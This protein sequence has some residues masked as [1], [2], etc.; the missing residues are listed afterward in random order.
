MKPLRIKLQNE[1]RSKKIAQH[2]I[3]KDYALSYVLAGISK[4]PKLSQSLIFKGGTALKKIFFGD[5]RFSEDLD[6]STINAPKGMELE[7]SLQNA[8]AISK[9]F[10]LQ[11]GPFELELKRNP[12]RA[13]HPN[14]QDAFNIFIKFP[15]QPTPMCRIKIEITHDEPVI[16]PPEYKP[17]LHNYEEAL[18][19][20]VVC[21][22]IEEIIAEKLRALLQTHQKLVARGWN[23]PRARDYYDLWCVLK[24]YKNPRAYARGIFP[25]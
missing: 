18:E 7:E 16:L 6:F 1:C 21:Y 24:K 19:C 4:H 13:P 22:P 15:W 25:I 9:E 10:L 23:R 3:E 11:Y 2:V 14:G 17:I 8:I 5:Y 20:I 12:E